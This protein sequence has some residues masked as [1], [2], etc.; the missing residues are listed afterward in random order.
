MLTCNLTPAF[1]VIVS[2]TRSRSPAVKC[3]RIIWTWS[4]N[5]GLPGEKS[6]VL[7]VQVLR[8]PEKIPF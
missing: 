3:G 4:T 5:L 1:I 7:F 2:S 6:N 8:G